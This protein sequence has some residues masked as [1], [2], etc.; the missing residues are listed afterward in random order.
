MIK[1]E[2]KENMPD[3]QDILRKNSSM[4]KHLIRNSQIS[5]DLRESRIS[6]MNHSLLNEEKKVSSIQFRRDSHYLNRE[7]FKFLKK[8]E[9]ERG[10]Q[11]RGPRQSL[12]DLLFSNVSGPLP[13]KSVFGN[14][15][16]N[17]IK[18]FY[19]NIKTSY[20]FKKNRLLIKRYS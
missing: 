1:T 2:I 20:L 5:N 17:I 11:E 16:G 3:I 15:I 8:R 4:L 7:K 10:K 18:I 12:K 14:A 19:I 9:E 6:Q 13:K